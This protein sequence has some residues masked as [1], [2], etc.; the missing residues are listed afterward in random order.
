M[1][2]QPIR[3]AI[4]ETAQRLQRLGLLSVTAGNLSARVEGELMAITPTGMPYEQ[5]E[6]QDI[7]ITDLVGNVVDGS[8]RP[9]S[10]LPFHLAVLRARSDVGAVVHTHS[11]Y[12]TTLAVLGRTIPAVHYV[13]AALDLETVPLVPYATFGSDELASGIA[14]AIGNGGK[15]ALLANHGALALGDD[16]ADAA[17]SAELLE[18]LATVYHRA[19]AVGEPV[20]LPSAEIA[21]VGDRYG[22]YGQPPDGPADGASA[23]VAGR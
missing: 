23:T 4:V 21:R 5:I 6:P 7:V 13:I 20:V 15:A 2:A 10:E 14:A 16:L 11:L 12:A 8:R 17:R 9:S 1:L 3:A 22:D 18:F 19:L